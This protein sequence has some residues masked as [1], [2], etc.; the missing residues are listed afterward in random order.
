MNRPSASKLDLLFQCAGAFHLP[1]E[2]SSSPS[3]QYGTDAHRYL[4]TGEDKLGIYGHIPRFETWPGDVLREVQL[5]MRPQNGDWLQD[6]FEYG[7]IMADEIVPDTT[8]F[9]DGRP[10]LPQGAIGMRADIMSFDLG[11]P[12]IGDLKTGQKTLGPERLTQLIMGAHI[13]DNILDNRPDYIEGIVIH[14]PRPKDDKPPKVRIRK[15]SYGKGFDAE[16][17]AALRAQMAAVTGGSDLA[18]NAGSECTFCPA[19][20]ACPNDA[21]NKY[22]IRRQKEVAE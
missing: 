1:W 5:W 6:E 10:L 21:K 20:A 18:L 3:A 19:K 22:Q 8:I 9:A 14:A 13:L 15:C 17:V 16:F 7:C 2:H 11:A 4:E 12:M